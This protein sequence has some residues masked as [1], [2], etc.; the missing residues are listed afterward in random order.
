MRLTVAGVEL[1][2]HGRNLL[3]QAE[4]AE[5][6]VQEVAGL[7]RG[8][9]RVAAYQTGAVRF[10]IP[11]IAALLRRRPG[12][13]VTFDELEP[14]SGLTAVAEG[15]VD[16]ALVN[17]YLGL[18]VPRTN[19][20]EV[21]DLGRDPFVLAAPARFAATSDIAPL[22]AFAE[23][24]WVS[25]RADTG[26]QAITELAAARAGFTPDII[27][28]ADNYD[29]VLEL[30]ASGV[31]VALVPRSAVRARPQVRIHEL[32]EPFDLTRRESLVTRESDHSPL[33][34]ELSDLIRRRYTATRRAR[35]TGVSSV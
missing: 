30:V 4:A 8:R 17:S 34:A 1:A 3:A 2:K 15:T 9:V 21:L 31:G 6:T 24:P 5:R 26:F 14:E 25:G 32:R 28:R 19:G 7:S 16:I 23:A 13:R 33:T 27:A 29:L 12:I 10:V 11:A 18:Q 35:P 20:I 22:A